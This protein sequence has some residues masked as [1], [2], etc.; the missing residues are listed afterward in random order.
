MAKREGTIRSIMTVIF[1]KD[2]KGNI[3]QITLRSKNRVGRKRLYHLYQALTMPYPRDPKTSIKAVLINVSDPPP[4][5]D[6][7][8]ILYLDLKILPEERTQE[9]LQ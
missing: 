3:N 5:V 1:S 9:R 8:Q 6:P 4:F 2:E 7:Q